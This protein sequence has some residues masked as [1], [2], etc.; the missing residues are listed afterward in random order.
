MY[1][2]I[3]IVDDKGEKG[4][5][6]YTYGT[7]LCEAYYKVENR[8]TAG[9]DIVDKIVR[10]YPEIRAKKMSKIRKAY[11]LL[12]ATGAGLSELEWCG[13]EDLN[14]DGSK[15]IREKDICNK[16]IDENKGFITLTHETRT[17]TSFL[18]DI[19]NIVIR[20]NDM[21]ILYDDLFDIVSNAS[22]IMKYQKDYGYEF[23]KLFDIGYKP[24]F[25]ISAIPFHKWDEFKQGVLSNKI[26]IPCTNIIEDFD[27]RGLVYM[28]IN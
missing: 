7:S 11:K 2:N 13:Y 8:T 9:F 25:P 3:I 21:S 1:I 14:I 17:L 5:Y 26:L 20:Y 27:K 15:A 28:R 18:K 10:A 19:Y 16:F 12:E 24:D 4:H 22:Y 6:Y 23:D